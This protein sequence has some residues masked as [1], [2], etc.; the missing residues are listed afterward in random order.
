MIRDNIWLE[1]FDKV[2]KNNT[3]TN[4]EVK[5][6]RVK[7]GWI[8]FESE[9]SRVIQEFEEVLKVNN[10]IFREDEGKSSWPE[11]LNMRQGEMFKRLGIKLDNNI[12]EG[13]REY[14]S[15]KPPS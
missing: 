8:D 13:L 9:I 10:N 4:F 15:V 2:Q 5:R 3:Q 1:H 11:L 14:V 7:D 12:L 6:A